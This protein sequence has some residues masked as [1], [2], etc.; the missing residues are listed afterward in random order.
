MDEP[1]QKD[2]EALFLPRLEEELRALRE[3]SVQTAANR[4]PVEL[5]QQS[6]GRLSRM[7]AIQQ[8]AMAFAQEARRN[9]RGRALEAAIARIA[10][11]EFGWCDNC[12]DFIGMGRLELDPTVTR[13]RDCAK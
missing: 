7:D 1:T 8:Q 6:V 2:L 9:G 12:G 5:D 10:T 4:K 11:P 13:C 3:A